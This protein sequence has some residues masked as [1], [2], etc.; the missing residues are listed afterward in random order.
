MDL[1]SYSIVVTVWMGFGAP[2]G[3]VWQQCSVLVIWWCVCVRGVPLL[4]VCLVQG[5]IR[6]H[7]YMLSLR[8]KQSHSQWGTAVAVRLCQWGNHHITRGT[9]NKDMIHY[10]STHTE[11][12]SYRDPLI[13]RSTHT[14]IFSYRGL[15]IQ[16]STHTEIQLRL[17]GRQSDRDAASHRQLTETDW[18]SPVRSLQ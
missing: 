5:T 7:L 9:T 8:P 17:T 16:R 14:E 15:L 3:D 4:S 2:P 18:T 13:Q 6:S 12:C 11:I 10:L 1:L